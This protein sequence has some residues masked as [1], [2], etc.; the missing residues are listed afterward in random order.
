[1]VVDGISQHID[2]S[3]LNLARLADRKLGIGFDQLLLIESPSEKENLFKYRIFN[4]DGS[5]VG[6]C[7]NGARCIAKFVRDQNLTTLDEFWVETNSGRIM[8]SVMEDEQVRV[9]MGVPRFEPEYIPLEVDQRQAQYALKYNNESMQFSALEIGNPHAVFEVESIDL[10][11]V[12]ELGAALQ[13]NPLFPERVNA[14]FYERLSDDEINLRVYERGVGETQA[15]GSGACAAVVAGVCLETLSSTT[16]VNLLGGSLL[17]E[18][19]GLGEA[20]FL[21]GPATTVYR[22]KLELDLV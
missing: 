1:M 4:A 7:G 19:A 20:V 2:V 12:H 18:Y 6:Q 16:R 5:E 10:A 21:T 15:C 22:G 3:E 9:N 11:P 14:G 8:L 17:I 13:T